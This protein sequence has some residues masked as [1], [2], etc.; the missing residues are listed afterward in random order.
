MQDFG[1]VFIPR[2]SQGIFGLNPLPVDP[3]YK[4]SRHIDALFGPEVSRALPARI[5]PEFSRRTG[6]IKNFGIDG[7]L[8]ATLRTDGGLALTIFGAQYLLDRSEGFIEN[9]VVASVDA[10]PFVSEGRSLF[11]RHVERC[12]S[13]IMPGSDVAVIDG[14]KVIAVGVS[15]L[16]AVLMNRFSRGVAVK[17]REGLRSRSEPTADKN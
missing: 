15:L 4:I 8:V 1:I 7:N 11:C 14:R 13:N 5:E 17:V 9:C 10:I 6:R 12:G 2:V 16:P 3:H